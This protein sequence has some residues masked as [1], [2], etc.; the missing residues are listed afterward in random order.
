MTVKAK[1]TSKGQITV[2]KGVRDQLGLR[3]GDEI[4]FVIENGG[5]AIHKRVTDNPFSEW[6]GY[7]KHLAGKDVDELIEEMRGR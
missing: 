3:P 4:E 5:C 7:L 1:M 2:P 6:R